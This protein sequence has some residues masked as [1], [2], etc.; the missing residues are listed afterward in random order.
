MADPFLIA[1]AE[2]QVAVGKA[3]SVR[4]ALREMAEQKAQRAERGL[5]LLKTAAAQAEPA[6]IARMK[7]HIA[8]QAAEFP[9]RYRFR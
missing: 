8:A 5:A 6:T 4:A 7:A 9:L 3:P 2:G 1:C